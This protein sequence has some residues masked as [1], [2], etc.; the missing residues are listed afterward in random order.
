MSITRLRNVH[1]FDGV[2]M[3]SPHRV[4][5]DSQCIRLVSEEPAADATDTKDSIDLAGTWLVPGL[6]D[7]HVHLELN[8]DDKEPPAP[9]APRDLDA[10]ADRA[11]AMVEAGITSARDLGGGS[12]AE[13]TIR[14]R[15]NAGAIPGPR[16]LCA[17]QPVT[18][19]QGHCHFWGGEVSTLAEAQ[20]VLDKQI[21]QGAD[22]FKIMA[23]GG[24]FTPNS[25][26]S[27]A[28]FELNF[29]QA[30]VKAANEAGLRVAA[31]CHG[32]EGI[33]HATHAGVTS[34]EH[35]SW[36]GEDGRWASDYQPE[37]AAEMARRGIWVSP[38]VGAGWQ[39]FLDSN[40]E[41]IEK[42]R[43]CFDDMRGKGVALIASTDA[44]I[45]GVYHHHL[46][47]AL[48]VFRQIAG[49]S[50][51]ET[52]RSAT[53]NAADALGLSDVTGRIKEGLAAD[54]LLLDSNPLED[55]TTLQ[56]PLAIW[57]RGEAVKPLG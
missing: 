26:P 38:T 57:A 48:E 1:L 2:E 50:H 29:M 51:L 3:H 23:T 53:A 36:V 35:C 55:L 19:M 24:R 49:L 21:E 39:R 56:R 7:A 5:F 44:G 33:H 43:A 4:E 31:H 42:F 6:T 45:P 54:L 14:D 13:F 25:S 32:S 28:Q 46:P 34:I 22:L 20:A 8:P 40:S 52:L 37:V 18:S 27:K 41:M 47:K 17:G 15:I 11:R 30:L 9:N 16:F 10:M 12:W